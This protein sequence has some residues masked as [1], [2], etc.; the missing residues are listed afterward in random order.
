MTTPTAKPGATRILS[1]DFTLAEKSLIRKVHGFMPPEQLLRLLN[2]RLECD[3]GAKAVK[4]TMEQLYTEISGIAGAV[5]AAGSG[6]AGLRKLLNKAR[7]DG[8]L[9]Q[10]N[11]QLIDDFAVVFSLSPKQVLN[12]KD[13]LL[14]TEEA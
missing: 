6:W 11:E 5:P 3:L 7:R 1:R 8:I 9:Q 4:Y 13:I 14:R 10:I 12:L 2:E